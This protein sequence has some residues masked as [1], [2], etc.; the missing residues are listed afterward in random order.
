MSGRVLQCLVF[1]ALRNHA[2]DEIHMGASL[3]V[4][5]TLPLPIPI[6]AGVD[7]YPHAAGA[8][9]QRLHA[10]LRSC[11]PAQGSGPASLDIATCMRTGNHAA[12]MGMAAA[13]Q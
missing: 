4:T 11:R 12:A 5:S 3:T 2:L 6:A 9:R 13:H 8:E 1:V 7:V 10:A